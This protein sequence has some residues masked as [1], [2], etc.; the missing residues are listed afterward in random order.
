ML[1][2]AI[3]LLSAYNTCTWQVCHCFYIRCIYSPLTKATNRIATKYCM[4]QNIH[5]RLGPAKV[6]WHVIYGNSVQTQ[7]IAASH[8]ML[9]ITFFLNK[10]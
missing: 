2:I 4:L 8:E 1:T 6:D 10:R 7:F 3:S 9:P 5:K